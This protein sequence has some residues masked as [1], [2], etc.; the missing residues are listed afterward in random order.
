M[1]LSI[2]LMEK[3]ASMILMGLFGYVAVKSGLMTEKD[4]DPLNILSLYIIG[5]CVMITSFQVELTQ[6]RLTGLA[7]T[8]AGAVAANG[9]YIFFTH[10]L[11]RPLRLAPV[12]RASMV[13]SNSG[14]LIIPL[15]S[16]VLG[17]ESVFYA[18]SYLVIQNVLFWTHLYATLS[19]SWSEVN[20]KKVLKNPNIIATAA[21]LALF[22]LR[23][24]LPEL[25][26]DT[27]SSVSGMIGPF[28]MILIGMIVAEADLKKIFIQRRVWLV[29]LFRLLVYPLALI[30]LLRL[31]GVTQL[32]AVAHSVLLVTLLGASA[33][34][35]C[36]VMQ[37]AL[38][39]GED[40]QEAG[41]INILSML[42]CVIT[43]PAVVYIYQLVL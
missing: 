28:S 6:E 23:I 39:C 1:E 17:A 7:I 34:S 35:A 12:E 42:L 4:Q 16:S 27:L 14:N 41:A 29:C 5:P 26:G 2:L 22:L 20:W 40:S 3:I 33:P 36:T 32:F 31:T 9:G 21:G 18:C 11:R 43:M 13:Y 19:G 8:L 37:M 24:T 10:L 30:L 38:L 15:V 25:V